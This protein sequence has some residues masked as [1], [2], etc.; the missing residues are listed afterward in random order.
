VQ[1]FTRLQSQLRHFRA[2]FA[3][4]IAWLVVL[5][6]TRPG[7]FD[8]TWAKMILLLAALVIAPLGV[9]L[10]AARTEGA[11]GWLLPAITLFQ[12]PA[13][14]A[15]G[16]AL[17][18][19]Q[20][21]PAALLALPWLLTTALIAWLGLVRVR[22]HLK[23]PIQEVC[24]DAGLVYIVVGGGWAVLDRMG[25]RPL[26]FEAIIVL[27]TAIHFHYA[28]FVLPII[29]GLCIGRTGGRHV[30][31]AALGVMAGVLMV[32]VGITATK[33]GVGPWL[34]CLAAWALA[35][36]GMLVSGLQL[37]IAL[38]RNS[39]TLVRILWGIAGLSLLASMALAALYGSRFYAPLGWLD[40]PW[41]RALHGTANSLGFA[42][43]GLAGWNLVEGRLG[44]SQKS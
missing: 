1:A 22:S 4:A 32:A 15:L 36:A 17:L 12:F 10:A 9:R 2:E 40:I 33:L 29:T 39:P 43:A 34:E 31:L 5:A 7:P 37:R 27:L 24:K 8:P 38:Q 18:I 44:V 41:M 23:G 28:G 6:A 35:V 26:D 21:W 42:L 20:G 13:A 19:P 30:R 25:S 16:V 3:G 11:P 14:L